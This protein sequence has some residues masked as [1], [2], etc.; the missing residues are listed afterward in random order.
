LG[1][2]YEQARPAA[3]SRARYKNCDYEHD[4]NEKSL[5]RCF[6]K[7]AGYVSALAIAIP[8][9]TD[10]TSSVL[11]AGRGKNPH[12]QRDAVSTGN[13]SKPSTNKN[14]QW[15]AD[16]DRGWVRSNESHSTQRR[17]RSSTAP[18]QSNGG[19]KGNSKASKRF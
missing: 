10:V 2:R 15:S 8:L 3:I 13:S 11:A 19:K 7:I 1:N 16:P 4:G 12:K 17:D 14:A 18:K 6:M 9:L 5:I